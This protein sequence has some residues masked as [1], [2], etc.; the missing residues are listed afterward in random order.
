[1]NIRKSTLDDIELL[2]MLRVDFLR[3]GGTLKTEDETT[4]RRQ[5]NRYFTEH[6]ANGTFIGVL[7]EIDGTAVSAAYLSISEKP[8][9]P[10]FIT[11][12]TGVLMNVLTYPAY[13]GR[14]IATRVIQRLM[15]EARQSG[16]RAIDL[17]ATESGKPLYEKLG[18]SVSNHTYMSIGLT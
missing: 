18:F 10:R 1:M 2:I 14:G 16:V 4:I 15:D 8:A 7:A 5:L 17:S 3:D 13:R 6:L 12:V 11:G 9:N